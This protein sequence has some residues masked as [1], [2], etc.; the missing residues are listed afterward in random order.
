MTTAL[1]TFAYGSNLLL[2]AMRERCPAAVPLGRARL[3]GYRLVFRRWA[4]VEPRPGES[5]AGGLWRITPACRDA[6]DDYEGVA[7]GLYAPHTLVVEPE[8]GGALEAL[9]Y[10]MTA[11]D[12]APPEPAYLA[13]VL[14]GHRDFGLAT[15]PVERAALASP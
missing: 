9:V 1:L 10:R 4:D 14:Q 8:G 13:A 12:T 11:T 2:S 3:A 6:L 7:E 15:G 5:V